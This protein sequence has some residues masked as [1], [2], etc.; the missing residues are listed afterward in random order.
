MKS[1]HEAI[2]NWV[3][4]HHLYQSKHS[5]L[6]DAYIRHHVKHCLHCQSEI[7]SIETLG[8]SIANLDFDF[9]STPSDASWARLSASLP[10]RDAS[11]YHPESAPS[12]VRT[13]F[14]PRA[15]AMAAIACTGVAFATIFIRG[16]RPVTTAVPQD[17]ASKAMPLLEN[18]A[19]EQSAVPEPDAALAATRQQA[20]AVAKVDGSESDPFSKRAPISMN[21]LAFQSPSDPPSNQQWKGVRK[22]TIV[23]IT[24]SDPYSQ[25][26][27][28]KVSMDVSADAINAQSP[29]F[30]RLAIKSSAAMDQSE[31]QVA[32]DN[33]SSNEVSGTATPVTYTPSAAME[34]TESQNRLRSL[35]Q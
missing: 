11:V 21:R 22:P 18:Q 15:I 5:G 23:A 7:Q 4:I 20:A 12:H 28:E 29:S 19:S 24:N 14:V 26:P 10:T 27:S 13:N 35:L 3:Q 6:R 31:H 30:P 33:M 8:S 2:C 25:I 9:S 17:I 1:L 32:T 34:L 16:N